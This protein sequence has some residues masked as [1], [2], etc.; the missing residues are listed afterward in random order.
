MH[1][2]KLGILVGG[3]PAPGINSVISSITLEAIAN[4]FEVIGFFEGYK[5][6]VKGENE[7]ILNLNVDNVS[8]ITPTGGSLLKTSR[9]SPA[10]SAEY[11]KNV[12]MAL[13]SL[14]IT[15]L[16]SIGGVNNAFDTMK[17]SE[18]AS[19][20]GYSLKTVHVP[21]TIDNDFP[22]PGELITFGFESARSFG[23]EIVSILAEDSQSTKRWYLSIIRGGET[24]HLT[25]GIGK[26]AA[27]TLTI[28]PEDFD[29]ECSLKLLVDTIVGAIFKRKT[30]GKTFGMAVV[31]EGIMNLPGSSGIE[32]EDILDW[33]ALMRKLK[34]PETP[35]VM[36]IRELLDDK[37]RNIIDLWDPESLLDLESMKIIAQGLDNIVQL[38]DPQKLLKNL[39][40][41]LCS[42]TLDLLMKYREAQDREEDL[43]PQQ[44]KRL[45]C[46]IVRSIFAKELAACHFL[47]RLLP[48]DLLGNPMLTKVDFK[49]LLR[50]EIIDRLSEFGNYYIELDD[51]LNWSDFL[52]GLKNHD[53][54]VKSHFW[55]LLDVETKELVLSW[56]P[57]TPFPEK[58]R[59]KL[60]TALNRIVDMKNFYDHDLFKKIELVEDCKVLIRR[61]TD[62]IA[63]N[64]DKDK[65]PGDYI[66]RNLP[67]KLTANRMRMFNRFLLKSIFPEEI[68]K[69]SKTRIVSKEIG[70]EL[71]CTPPVSSDLEYTRNLGWAAFDFLKHGNS[72]GVVY[73]T[74]NSYENLPFCKLF[75]DPQ[76]EEP[77]RRVD[78]KSVFYRIAREYM[79]M[80][81]PIDFDDPIRLKKLAETAGTTP[82]KFFREFHYVVEH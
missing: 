65:I 5:H 26:S 4:G 16:V 64:K 45:N 71:R 63:P 67:V 23:M 62:Q 2:K 29:G 11:L 60:V 49:T 42:Q 30:L 54:D 22:L 53:S 28:I 12:I 31:A 56:E 6:L 41:R 74:G 55:T 47:G 39:P 52:I 46:L 73:I 33:E 81:E 18:F 76:D 61:L 48:R 78:R 44:L 15:H 50:D 70:Y 66:T 40:L 17:V 68:A 20:E 19:E 75:K 72:D 9:T 27:A 58:S 69:L 13:K 59:A 34:K 32:V 24:G 25:L 14:H 35:A 36:R 8:R 51:I 1:N 82:E 79:I 37:S 3:G 57:K 77:I 7:Q 21:K 10:H 38:P 80:L 43:S